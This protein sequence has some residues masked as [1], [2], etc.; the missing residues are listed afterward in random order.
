MGNLLKK[1]PGKYSSL[2]FYGDCCLCCSDLD[3]LSKVREYL[4]LGSCRAAGNFSHLEEEG[5]THIINTADGMLKKYARNWKLNHGKFNYFLIDLEDK[6]SQSIAEWF[7]PSYHFIENALAKSTKENPTKILCHCVQGK[8]R[9]VTI[10]IAYL[11]LKE[12]ISVDE[13]LNQ[14]RAVRDVVH[15][16]NSGF[17]RQLYEFEKKLGIRRKKGGRGL[18]YSLDI[19]VN[20]RRNIQGSDEEARG[21]K[22]RDS[23]SMASQG[24]SYGRISIGGGGGTSEVKLNSGTVQN[25]RNMSI[26]MADSRL[27]ELSSVKMKGST[28][29]IDVEHNEEKVS[30]RPSHVRRSE[31]AVRP[32]VPTV[33]TAPK[34]RSSAKN[35]SPTNGEE[36]VLTEADTPRSRRSSVGHC[37]RV[38]NQIA[39]DSTLPPLSTSPG[40]MATPKMRLRPPDTPSIPEDS[41]EYPRSLASGNSVRV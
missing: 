28:Y 7:E 41:N 11:M 20:M 36:S 30:R 4:Y 12:A 24:T 10:V 39:I 37:K 35:Y 22:A 13:A 16:P 2:C 34:S 26:S 19:N 25:G 15:T 9:S 31:R 32:A 38:E 17:M 8:S 33:S 23:P 29:D 14:I 21:L 1:I 27:V 18:Q 5:I 3:R 40:A 6:S